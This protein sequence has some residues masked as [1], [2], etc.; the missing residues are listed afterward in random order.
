MTNDAWAMLKAGMPV[1]LSIIVTPGQRSQ[2]FPFM[3]P[4]YMSSGFHSVVIVI[5]GIGEKT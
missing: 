5:T 4:W 2:S 1:A 3:M